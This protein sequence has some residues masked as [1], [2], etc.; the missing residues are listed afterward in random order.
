VTSMRSI[1]AAAAILA[2][3]LAWTSRAGIE[4][5]PQGPAAQPGTKWTEQQL[6]DAV[7]PARVGKN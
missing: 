7:A 3:A 5:Q 1:V 4:A 2:A 6:R